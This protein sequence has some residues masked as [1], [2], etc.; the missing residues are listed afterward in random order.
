MS[1]SSTTIS[2]G[3]SPIKLV[4]TTAFGIESVAAQEIKDLGF[5]GI[6]TENSRVIYEGDHLGIVLSNLWL[7]TPDRIY[8][9]MGT[10]KALTFEELFQ[11]VSRIEWEKFIDAKGRFPVEAK[12]VKSQLFS[13]SDIQAI[14]KK[15]MVKRLGAHYKTEWFEESAG[16]YRVVVSILKDQVSVLLDTSGEALH[17]RG[18]RSRGYQ[19]P[20]KETLSAALI[21]ISRWRPG[22]QL[23]DPLCGTGTILIEAA[24][25]GRNIAPGLNRKFASEKWPLF[26]GELYPR[27]RKKAFEAIDHEAALH[28]EGYDQD[29]RAIK[30]AMENALEA[31]V[32]EDI[33]FQVRRLEAFSTKRAYGYIITNPPYGERLGEKAQVEALYRQMGEVFN[34]L[35]T[36][37]KYILTSM[38]TFEENF[39][40][41]ATKNRKLYNGRIKAYFYQYYGEKP[42][43]G[44]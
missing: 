13:L 41:K 38:E 11:G 26:P 43:R 34:P 44:V 12:S 40:H 15:A 9:L 30:I 10:F 4:A 29:S 14:S 35:A 8:I 2:K 21:K 32:A 25:M 22:I 16:T 27:E 17:K 18:Y 3:M 19:A 6:V 39:G 7:R 33:H 28:L 24:M 31:G 23:V 1:G 36:W 42:K 5:E 37:S 20:L